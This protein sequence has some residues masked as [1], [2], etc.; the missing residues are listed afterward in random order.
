MP[1]TTELNDWK[2]LRRNAQ[3]CLDHA[4]RLGFLV[5]KPCE[6]CG[7]EKAD[8]H[9]TDYSRPLEVRWL[10]RSH[11]RKEHARLTRLLSKPSPPSEEY[12]ALLED[13]R[14]WCVPRGR[15]LE[16]ARKMEVS[17]TLVT[18]WLR[19]ERLLSL[20]QWLAIKKIIGRKR[21]KAE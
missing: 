16:L 9:H 7:N 13:L 2:W 21:P 6:V 15:K 5:R 20:E 10:C 14:A 11:H 12:E 1:A 17:P 19:G 18:F 4:L 8:G 3:N